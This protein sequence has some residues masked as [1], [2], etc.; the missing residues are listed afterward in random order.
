MVCSVLAA[1]P[2]SRCDTRV[3]ADMVDPGGRLLAHLHS[4]EGRSPSLALVQIQ[5]I[6]FAGT[7]LRSLATW[8]ND[9]IIIM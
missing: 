5:R 2:K 1:R 9:L 6:S 3:T 4:C 7:S 8:P